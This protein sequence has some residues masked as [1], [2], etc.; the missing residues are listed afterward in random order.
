MDE[1]FEPIFRRLRNLTNRHLDDIWDEF[2][3]FDAFPGHMDDPID[4]R[5]I[6]EDTVL[7]DRL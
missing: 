2:M 1:I 7:I 3:R 6:I 5:E 4:I